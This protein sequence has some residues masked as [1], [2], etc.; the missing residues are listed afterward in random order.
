MQGAMGPVD[1]P[2]LAHNGAST[3]P[4]SSAA[5]TPKLSR[6]PVTTAAALLTVLLAVGALQQGTRDSVA[7]PLVGQPAPD[8]TLTTFGGQAVRLSDFRGRPVVINFWASWCPPCRAEAPTLGNVA[9][10][11]QAAGRAAFIGIDTRDQEESA[12]EFLADFS[13]PYPNGPD[14]QNLEAEYGSIGL[15]YTVFVDADGTIARTWI[16]PLDE[17]RLVA[18]I[19][20]IA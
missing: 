13:I 5:L 6:W 16:G 14:T 12:R 9:R 4:T 11:E 10:A 3:S 19:D 15:P 2:M 1:D 7:G 18:I 17:Q 8:F 20:E